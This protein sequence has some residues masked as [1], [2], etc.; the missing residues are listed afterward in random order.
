MIATMKLRPATQQQTTISE[1]NLF[2]LLSQYATHDWLAWVDGRE[3]LCGHGT[4]KQ[5]AVDNL[6]VQLSEAE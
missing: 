3:G 6:L 5:Q 1:Q 4:T 2:F